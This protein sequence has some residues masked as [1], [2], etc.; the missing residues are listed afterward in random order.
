[1]L[2]DMEMLRK[3]QNNG[4]Q[5]EADKVV[6]QGYRLILHNLKATYEEIMND[7]EHEVIGWGIVPYYVHLHSN[8]TDLNNLRGE[9]G[10]WSGKE[11][12][13]DYFAEYF[14]LCRNRVQIVQDPLLSAKPPSV[15]DFVPSHIVYE[16]N[17]YDRCFQYIKAEYQEG[18]DEFYQLYVKY[19][20]GKAAFFESKPRVIGFYLKEI[21]ENP[22]KLTNREYGEFFKTTSLSL[23]FRNAS[24]TNIPKIIRGMDCFTKSNYETSKMKYKSDYR[25]AILLI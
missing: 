25:F 21:G 3:S 17:E 20:N 4:M 14:D 6:G 1:M 22:Y 12:Y 15:E 23:F 2:I 24:T 11:N 10:G 9:F 16:S 5:F 18:L 13:N 8:Q 7:E 19:V